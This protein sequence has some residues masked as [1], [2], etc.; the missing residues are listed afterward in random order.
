MSA[1]SGRDLW[2]PSRRAVAT[3]VAGLFGAGCT[4][5]AQPDS[6]LIAM[7]GVTYPLKR[8]AGQRYL[9]DAV[10]KP[11]FLNGDT[12]WSMVSGLNREDADFYLRDRA[13]RDVNT[14]MSGVL[15]RYHSRYAPG[16]PYGALPFKKMVDFNQPND[17]YFEHLDW[18]VARAAELGILLILAPSWLGAQ[19]TMGGYYQEMK[20]AGPEAMRSYGR[21][22]GNR[23]KA[24]TNIMWLMGGDFSPPERL[25]VRN[26]AE[27]I[28]EGGSTGL[29]TAHCAPYASPRDVWSGES[30]LDLDN[31]YSYGSLWESALKEHARPERMPY[32]MV[33]SLY[34]NE[35]DA[36]HDEKRIRRQPYEAVLGGAFGHMIG[37]APIWH[38]DG[39][40]SKGRTF[41]NWRDYLDT[42]GSRSMKVLRDVF[43]SFAWWRLEPDTTGRLLV[44]AGDPKP[45]AAIDAERR[46][47]ICYLPDATAVNVRL[48]VF[49]D[50]RR[51]TAEWRDPSNGRTQVA[52]Q[53]ARAGDVVTFT[54][55][56]RPGTDDWLLILRAGG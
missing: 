25:L 38:A 30:W 45:V 10:G 6:D 11:F 27:G 53:G 12:C 42:P 20:A 46:L 13:A 19:G 47:A 51:V 34:E 1:G 40:G 9:V 41:P 21:Y 26:M 35:N 24:A 5:R 16:N 39:P 2:R 43:T 23:Y 8:V 17:A 29:R 18:L 52:A 48:S 37:S 31:L 14:V 55:P 56:P 4:A 15:C 7:P 22:L 32:F 36:G 3:G 33:E 44:A 49:P 50:A 54:P 28:G